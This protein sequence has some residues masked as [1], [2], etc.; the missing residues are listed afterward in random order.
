MSRS[1]RGPC[2]DRAR[3]DAPALPRPPACTWAFT[4][5]RLP[6]NSLA[7]ATPLRAAGLRPGGREFEF[8]EDFFR[9]VFVRFI[10]YGSWQK[11]PVF[12]RNRAA[13]ATSVT[14]YGSC[15]SFLLIE[16]W[17]MPIVSSPAPTDLAWRVI[18]LVNLYRLRSTV[19][20]RPFRVRWLGNRFGAAHGTVPVDPRVF[21]P[22]VAIVIGGGRLLLVCVQP[23]S[24][25]RWWRS[26][27]LMSTAAWRWARHP[28]CRS[29]GLMGSGR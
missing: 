6:P 26:I 5:H 28:V 10:R 21:H 14:G 8:A 2:R 17:P 1:R 9:L 29:R 25:T 19:A 20:L 18:G 23:R 11:E 16:S 13:V 7:T 22:G 12:S 27:V 15:G 24:F 3:L 4:T